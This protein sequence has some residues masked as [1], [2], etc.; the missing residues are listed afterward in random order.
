MMTSTSKDMEYIL[1]ILCL[2]VFTSKLVQSED[3]SIWNERAQKDLKDSLNLVPNLNKAKNVILFLGDGMGIN[4]VSAARLYKAQLTQQEEGTSTL[5]FEKFPYIALSKTYNTDRQTPDSAG[6]ATAFLCG[7]KANLGTVGVNSNVPRFNCS[8]EEGNTVQ[9]I[10]DWSEAEGKS[11]GIVT[12]ARVTHATPAAAYAHSA[13][14]DWEND[15]NANGSC[16]DIARQLI[17]DNSHIEVIL[18][19]GQ[20]EF[21]PEGDGGRRTDNRTLTEE[22]IESIKAKKKTGH[23]VT[24]DTEFKTV[25]LSKTDHLLGLFAMSHM[26]YAID[27]N[28]SNNEN[29]QPSLAEMTATALKILQ[30]ND[31]GFFLLVEGARIDHGHHENWAKRALYDTIAFD[32]A[33]EEALK[34]TDK[35]DTLIVVTADHSHA[36]TMAGYPEKGNDIFG[37]VKPVKEGSEPEDGLP[38]L[39]LVYGNGKGAMFDNNGTRRNFTD[40]DTHNNDFRFHAAVPLPYETHAAEDVGIFATGPMSH[41]FHGVHE[42]NYIAHVM[43]YASCVGINKDHCKPKPND[44]PISGTNSEYSVIPKVLFITVVYILLQAFELP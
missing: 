4:S 8:L 43:A 34:N 1:S 15:V 14:R 44:G 6:T 29:D 39:S 40:V 28:D 23:Y 7:V 35:E 16:K 31:K 38:Y 36:F 32:E 10:I 11:T 5:A 13:D 20:R 12:T 41:L 33:V 24:T 2:A 37:I 9:S 27:R 25:D 21:I 22:W 30:K 19:G 3:G 18:G 26:D 17:E 42:Q